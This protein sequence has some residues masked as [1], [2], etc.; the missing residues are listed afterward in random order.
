[1]LVCCSFFAGDFARRSAYKLEKLLNVKKKTPILWSL[2]SHQKQMM[3]GG[4]PPHK[5]KKQR[6]NKALLRA[7]KG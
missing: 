7:A 1:M 5:K 3:M 6:L 4:Q 2:K